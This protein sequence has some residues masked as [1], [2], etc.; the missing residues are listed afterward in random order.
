MRDPG[1]PECLSTATTSGWAGHIIVLHGS[2]ATTLAHTGL[3]SSVVLAT[4]VLVQP[5]YAN[6][7]GQIHA[8]HQSA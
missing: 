2:A 3:A 6:L 4:A 1:N 5:S 8:V 7:H